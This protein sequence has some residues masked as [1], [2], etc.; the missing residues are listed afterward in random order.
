MRIPEPLLWSLAV[1]GLALVLLL[2]ACGFVMLAMW[3]D[4]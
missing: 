2:S 3:E 4:E 1:H